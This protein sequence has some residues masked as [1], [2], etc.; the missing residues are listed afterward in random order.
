ML[1]GDN[2]AMKYQLISPFAALGIV[3]V[4][5]WFLGMAE[6]AQAA[7]V[8]KVQEASAEAKAEAKKG[9]G[10]MKQLSATAR[11]AM[12]AERMGLL[13]IDAADSAYSG[14]PVTDEAGFRFYPV[15][16]GSKF[17]GSN[18]KEY[19]FFVERDIARQKKLPGLLGSEL[20]NKALLS[21]EIA[22]E[23]LVFSSMAPEVT[24]LAQQTARRHLRQLPADLRDAWLAQEAGFIHMP[25]G[26][27]PYTEEK[28]EDRYGTIDMERK[29]T[30]RGARP[31]AIFR[32]SKGK[33]WKMEDVWER[34]GLSGKVPYS[35]DL[36]RWCATL[37]GS[38]DIL[39]LFPKEVKS[40]KKYYEAVK[41]VAAPE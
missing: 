20:W 15:K 9:V 24:K 17:V 39:S 31:E 34:R 22:G 1:S 30:W 35:L 33:E 5:A 11:Q 4:G 29:V 38:N 26:S 16:H 7:Y 36:I 6:P 18:G 14:R 37:V 13:Y 27:D 8:P 41:P 19:D 12:I 3:G 40:M 23:E 21:I 25:D 32:D 28:S 2:V 10:A